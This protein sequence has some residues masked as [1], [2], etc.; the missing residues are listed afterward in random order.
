MSGI[1]ADESVY[2]V[3]R[4]QLPPLRRTWLQEEANLEQLEWAVGVLNAAQRLVDELVDGCERDKKYRGGW[5][6]IGRAMGMT[7][8][9]AAQ[10]WKRRHRDTA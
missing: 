8:Q 3:L 4:E 10:S 9:G 5:V 2:L 7:A 1:P 6:K